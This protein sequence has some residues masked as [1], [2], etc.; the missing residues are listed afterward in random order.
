[1]KKNLKNQFS[2]LMIG[3]S[4]S[5]DTIEYL[6]QIANSIGID[7]KV[8]NLYIGGCSLETHY[9]NII[10]DNHLYEFRV[11]NQE[12]KKWNS[13]PNQSIKDGINYYNWDYI[14][15]QQASGFSGIKETYNLIPQLINEIKKYN[16]ITKLIWNMTWA[17]QSD[18]DHGHFQFYSN[19]QSKMYNAIVDCVTTNISSEL[20]SCIIPIGTAIQNARTSFM[21]DHLTRDGFHLS[22]DLGRYIAGLTLIKKMTDC[23][24]NQ[25]TFLPDNLSE[26]HRL[27]AIESATNAILSPFKITNSIYQD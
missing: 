12:E 1:M 24:L 16:S 21:G 14:S 19:N 26:K 27:L 15:L 4:F 9:N 10:N 23:D 8:C 7:I 22:Y 20:F 3:N 13:I 17:Y 6:Y 25:V 2:L 11:Y 5:D 18:S